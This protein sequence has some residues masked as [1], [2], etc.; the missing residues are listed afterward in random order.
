MTPAPSIPDADAALLSALRE[1]NEALKATIAMSDAMLADATAAIA[2]RDSLIA[3]YAK[4]IR[5]NHL[6]HRENLDMIAR[7]ARL[8]SELERVRADNVH[9]RDEKALIWEKVNATGD[10]AQTPGQVPS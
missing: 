3:G 6:L 4:L 9:L 7:T 10:A 1:E 2:Q 8:A 5:E